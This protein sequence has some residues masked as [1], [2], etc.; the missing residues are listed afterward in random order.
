SAVS[1]CVQQLEELLGTR[2]VDRSKRPP[3]PTAE[4]KCFYDGCGQLLRQYETLV[5][6]V[7]ALG[8]QLSG[9]VKFEWLLNKP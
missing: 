9:R 7:Q 8:Q 3:T 6:E 5:D 1:Q 2:L 4:G